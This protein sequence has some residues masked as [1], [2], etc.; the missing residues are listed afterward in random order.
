[1]WTV[2]ALVFFGLL[3]AAGSRAAAGP[4]GTSPGPAGAER[5]CSGPNTQ[6]LERTIRLRAGE[7][8]LLHRRLPS[9]S[10]SRFNP[11][12]GALQ[13][14]AIRLGERLGDRVTLIHIWSTHCQPCVEE[15]PMLLRLFEALQEG[16]ALRLLLVAEEELSQLIPFAAAHL[17]S[18]PGIELATLSPESGWREQLGDRSLPLTLLIDRDLI[19]R[20]AFLG[21]L[22]ERRNEL[23]SAIEQLTRGRGN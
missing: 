15:M 7:S 8:A 4:A 21:S 13:E 16:R 5:A 11:R 20:Q 14:G 18:R 22:K 17:E 12:T 9:R 19:V 2:R 10:L 1:M 6:E 23:L 3:A